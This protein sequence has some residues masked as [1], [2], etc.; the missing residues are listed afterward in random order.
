MC[1][2]STDPIAWFQHI[3]DIKNENNIRKCA[4][5][6]CEI[7]SDK[8]NDV[9][10]AGTVTFFNEK[11]D[12]WGDEDARDFRMTMTNPTYLD[13]WK[14]CDEMIYCTRDFHH[15]F[16]EDYHMRGDGTYWFSMGS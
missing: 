16:L 7:D 12:Y 11:D 13:L 1:K 5:S 6:I 3:H 9:A 15:I 14:A 2:Y 8:L 4:F 10:I